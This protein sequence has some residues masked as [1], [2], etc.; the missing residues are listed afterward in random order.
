M[1]LAPSALQAIGQ[2]M[3]ALSG[4]VRLPLRSG[5]FSGVSGSV[6]GQGTGNSIDYQDQRQ[7]MAGDDPRHINW[8]AYAR[9][10]LYTMKLYRQ[11]V[12]PRVDMLFDCTDSMFLTEEKEVR[13]WETL[14]FCLESAMRLGA[15]VKI[16]AL[17]NVVKEVPLEQALS[18]NWSFLAEAAAAPRPKASAAT[19]S[20]A[21][22]ELVSRIPLRPGSLRVLLSDLLSAAP[23]EPLTALLMQASGRAIVL[24]PFCPDEAQPDWSGNIQFE[25]SESWFTDRRRVEKDVLARYHRAY[26]NHFALWRDQCVRRGVGMARVGSSGK[27]IDA[28]RAEAL[29]NGVVEMH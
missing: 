10:G 8:Q 3:K 18:G 15:S 29:L 5:K 6:F 27:L 26:E 17:R 11:E 21:L 28:F 12:T 25:D 22:E 13:V 23:P 1:T 4:V 16:Y 2:R 19:T 9:T 24:S 7:Y 20:P 14:Y